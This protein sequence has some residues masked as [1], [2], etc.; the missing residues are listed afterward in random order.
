[1]KKNEMTIRQEFYFRFIAASRLREYQN[2]MK[3]ALTSVQTTSTLFKRLDI[4]HE[5]RRAT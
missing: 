2:E 1:M 3:Q 4:K 5:I